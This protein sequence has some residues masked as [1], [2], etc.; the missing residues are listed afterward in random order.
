MDQ[1]NTYD[2]EGHIYKKRRIEKYSLENI[3]S[4]LLKQIDYMSEK[5]SSNTENI[6]NIKKRIHVLDKPVH[7]YSYSYIG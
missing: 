4:K 2:F 5:I 7:D 6:D 3:I 1:K